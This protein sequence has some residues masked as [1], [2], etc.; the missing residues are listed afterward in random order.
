MNLPHWLI[1]HFRPIGTTLKIARAIA[2]GS[3]C[4]THELDLSDPEISG[5]V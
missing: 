2:K 5:H 4:P 1:V 3:G